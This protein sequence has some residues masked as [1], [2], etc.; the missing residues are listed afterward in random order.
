MSLCHMI[1]SSFRN[2]SCFDKTA[3]NRVGVLLVGA[4]GKGQEGF[5]LAG[6]LR[7]VFAFHSFGR[8]GQPF[9]SRME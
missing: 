9:L 1:F 3:F 2:P 8:F 5:T 4:Q 7:Q 6:Y